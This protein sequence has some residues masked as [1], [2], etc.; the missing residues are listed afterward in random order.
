M[1]VALSNLQAGFLVDQ[2]RDV[3]RMPREAV[4]EA[5]DLTD[6][7]KLFDRVATLDNG[8]RVVLLIDPVELLD[9]A[10][11]E[12]LIALRDKASNKS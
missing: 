4:T 9:D 5:P 11:R 12:M 7:M 3:L 8:E 6:D 10:E 1:I 2:V